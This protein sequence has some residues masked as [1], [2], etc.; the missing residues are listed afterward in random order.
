MGVVRGAQEVVIMGERIGVGVVHA[1]LIT[2]DA[3]PRNPL[4]N[5]KGNR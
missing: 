2:R 4:S 3:F 1:G 5:R